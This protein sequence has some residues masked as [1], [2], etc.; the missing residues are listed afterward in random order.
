MSRPK[1]KVSSMGKYGHGSVYQRGRI[2]WIQYWKTGIPYA[3][4]SK[5]SDKAE[6]E[7]LL[8]QRLG[9][10]ATD[11]LQGTASRKITIAQLCDLVIEDY[12]ISKKRSLADVIW[13]TDKNIKRELGKIRAVD[14]GTA[15]I[16]KYITT[17][18]VEGAMDGTINR[19]LTIVRRGF[20]LALKAD[21][22][23]VSRAPYIC[24]LEEDNARQGF[25]EDSQ[26][27]KVRDALPERL[28]AL[29]VV[30]Y[31][32][33]VR[34]GELRKIEWSQVDLKA[35]E[36]RLHKKQTKGKKARTIPIYGE[37][38]SWLEM[39]KARRDQMW[40]ACPWVFNH[41][42]RG[43]DGHITGFVEACVAAGVPNLRFHDLRRSAIRNMERAGIPRKIAMEISG[44]KTEAVYRRYD[45]VSPQDIRLAAAKMENYFEGLKSG[46]G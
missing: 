25:L 21:P 30:G 34:L 12:K 32:V 37:M 8:C 13:R 36:I 31:H 9:E 43:L 42:N 27:V 14:F 17:R 19:E 16:Q 18:R 15:H 29:F 44:H 23:L 3:E 26:Y 24:R 6:A 10:R 1:G 46:V 45:I 4:S 2:W 41:Y 40:P 7:R 22:P 11:R 28:K 39:Q 33:G 20:S 38:R 5:S 35:G